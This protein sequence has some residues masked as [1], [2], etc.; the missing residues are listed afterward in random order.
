MPVKAVCMM[1]RSSAV[2]QESPTN[3]RYHDRASDRWVVKVLPGSQH[4]SADPNGQELISTVLGSCVAACVHDPLLG[5]GGM[6]HFMLPHDDE[7][8]WSGASLA[9][10]YGNHAMDAL[11]NGLLAAGADKRRL[12]CKIFGGGNVVNGM[13][14]VG[15]DNAQFAREYAR[16]E[17]LNVVAFDL[18][19]DRGRR[20]VFDPY[21]GQAWRRFLSRKLVDDV[22]RAERKL[23][24]P[25]P[26][27]ARDSSIE[28]F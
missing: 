26:L 9:L 25:P 21:T 19:G 12:E 6:N 3:G 7:G 27:R 15:D 28:L 16:A 2:R 20:I 23:R 10:R 24:Q 22:A 1:A 4:V 17:G 5:I 11:I 18:G 8:L 14:G 13:S